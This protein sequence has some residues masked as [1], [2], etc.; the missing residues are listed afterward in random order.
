MV[1]GKIYSMLH[2]Q[3]LS[4]MFSNDYLI[5]GKPKKVDGKKHRKE[6]KKMKILDFGRNRNYTQNKTDS[7]NGKKQ[8]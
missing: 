8:G 7:E 5:Q 1:K 3:K 2:F 6:E 4:K